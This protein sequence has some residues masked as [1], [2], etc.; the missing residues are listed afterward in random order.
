MNILI[1]SQVEC[2][3]KLNLQKSKDN[4]SHQTFAYFIVFESSA[5]WRLIYLLSSLFCFCY[6]DSFHLSTIVEVFKFN[7]YVCVALYIYKQLVRRGCQFCVFQDV[8]SFLL[9]QVY[10]IVHKLAIF[11][12]V[13]LN[14]IDSFSFEYQLLVLISFFLSIGLSS[15]FLTYIYF[16][17]HS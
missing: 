7:M 14:I 9:M 8:N 11:N 12:I 16:L 17:F 4:F 2:L 5:N 3:A 15:P 10:I 1:G 13:S 6:L